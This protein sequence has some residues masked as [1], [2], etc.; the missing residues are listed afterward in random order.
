[1]QKT[2]IDAAI[3]E[4]LVQPLEQQHELN[5]LWGI[6]DFLIQYHLGHISLSHCIHTLFKFPNLQ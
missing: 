1:M 2:V 5:L 4:I 6:N 3:S